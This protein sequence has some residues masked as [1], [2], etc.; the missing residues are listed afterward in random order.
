MRRLELVAVLGAV[1]IALWWLGA[2]LIGAVPLD[3]LGDEAARL[4]ESLKASS[5]EGVVSL[6][7]EGARWVELHPPGD[8][9]FRGLITWAA[10]PMVSSPDSLVRL[11]QFISFTCVTGGIGIAA[12]G[13]RQRW[14][15][16]SA[17][18]FAL[19]A[20]ASS[21]VV[22]VAHHIIGEAPT[23]LFVG[24]AIHAAVVRNPTDGRWPY[25]VGLPLLAA[26]LFRPE[27]AVVFGGLALIPLHQRRVRAAAIVGAFAVA[28]P[29]FTTIAVEVSSNPGSYASIRLFA[30]INFVDVVT[31]DRMR[32]IIWGLGV[33]PYLGI[34]FFIAVIGAAASDRRLSLGALLTTGWL[35]LAVLFTSQIAVGAIHQQERAYVFPALFGLFAVAVVVG[36]RSRSPSGRIVVVIV[37]ALAV[38][39][40][41][42]STVQQTYP[43]WQD[44]VPQDAREVSTVLADRSGPDDAI[45]LDWLWWQEWRAAIYAS[46]ASNSI[47]Y[48]L[49][50]ECMTHSQ[51]GLVD[52]SGLSQENAKRLTAAATFVRD[53]R[54]LHV[55]VFSEEKQRMWDEWRSNQEPFPSFVRPLFTP[56]EDRCWVARAELGGALYCPV[57]SNESYVVFELVP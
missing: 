52:T 6:L 30:R 42:V 26:A 57:M 24:L 13:I 2:I 35:A 11:Q 18:T 15:A 43:A 40:A 21:P 39:S 55:V 4:L 23:V 36:E 7:T 3:Y 5:L 17:I 45:L 31:D 22:Y 16:T 47:R 37:S 46:G 8:A 32:E 25:S 44:R 54:P 29:V 41:L 48:C 50:Y 38:T 14:G 33:I 9:A 49:Y 56:N 1:G 27:A 10:G 12:H 34:G 20:M 53:Q 28:F 51:P 19:G